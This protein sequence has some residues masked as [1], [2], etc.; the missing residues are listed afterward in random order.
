MFAILTLRLGHLKFLVSPRSQ[1][2]KLYF[3]T[4]LTTQ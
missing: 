2:E 4:Q 3:R 1:K